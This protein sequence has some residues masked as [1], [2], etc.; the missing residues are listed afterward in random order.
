MELSDGREPSCAEDL[1]LLLGMPSLL[2]RNDMLSCLVSTSDAACQMVLHTRC[3][4]HY[5]VG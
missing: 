5:R 3:C 4:S 1:L 2:N